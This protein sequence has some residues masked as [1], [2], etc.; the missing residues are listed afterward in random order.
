[1]YLCI[2]STCRLLENGYQVKYVTNTTKESL[3]KLYGRLSS[4]G[5]PVD[6]H[7]IFTSLSAAR[8]LLKA[9]HLSPLL[10]VDEKAEEDFKGL[11]ALIFG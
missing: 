7:E 8:R 3:N 1:M 11:C 9:R 6:G 2:V 10:L 5:F 4:M